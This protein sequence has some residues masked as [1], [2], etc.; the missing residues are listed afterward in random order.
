MSLT[1]CCAMQVPPGKTLAPASAILPASAGIT[2]TANGIP[3][4][5]HVQAAAPTGPSAGL[6]AAISGIGAGAARALASHMDSERM[7]LPAVAEQ[8]G[9]NRYLHACAAARTA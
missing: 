4:P 7:Q 1:C 6:P 3:A 8:P 2:G 9:S 5:G